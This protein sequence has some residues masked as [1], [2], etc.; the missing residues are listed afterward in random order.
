MLMPKTRKRFKKDQNA[1]NVHVP[2]RAV[3]VAW[4][5]RTMEELCQDESHLF[6]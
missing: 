1:K 6:Q 5:I 2:V 4:K 3:H